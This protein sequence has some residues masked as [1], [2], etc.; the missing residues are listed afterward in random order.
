[1]PAVSPDRSCPTL[2]DLCGSPSGVSC[3]SNTIRVDPEDTAQL[4]ASAVGTA[5]DSLQATPGPA[6]ATT[7]EVIGESAAGSVAPDGVRVNHTRVNSAV[8]PNQAVAP[9]SGGVVLPGGTNILRGGWDST[10]HGGSDS[11]TAQDIRALAHFLER[12]LDPSLHLIHGADDAPL[13]AGRRVPLKPIFR[14][15]RV[16]EVRVDPEIAARVLGGHEAMYSSVRRWAL[17]RWVRRIRP[18]LVVER[19]GLAALDRVLVERLIAGS[20]RD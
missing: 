14:N 8:P 10:P 19:R 17:L 13:N 4:R 5:A 18:A 15:G 6:A 12:L 16:Q 7:P 9:A 11:P 3:R 2:N 1:M 20:S